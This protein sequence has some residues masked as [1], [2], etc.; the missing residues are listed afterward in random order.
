MAM[1]SPDRLFCILS[2]LYSN[3]CFLA[4]ILQSKLMIAKASVGNDKREG[5][6]GEKGAWGTPLLPEIQRRC[7]ERRMAR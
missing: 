1:F 6:G 2:N 3:I 5:G 7:I 4:F